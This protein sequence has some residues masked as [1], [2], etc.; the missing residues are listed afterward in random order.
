MTDRQ[1][2]GPSRPVV[3][4][5]DDAGWRC[6]DQ[7]A[8]YLRRVGVRSV[9]VVLRRPPNRLRRLTDRMLYAEVVSLGSPAGTDRLRALVAGGQVIDAHVNE[10]TLVALGPASPLA[11]L[12]GTVALGHP[13]PGLALVDKVQVGDRLRAGGALVPDQVRGERSS[14]AEAVA[15]LGLPLVVKRRIGTGGGEVHVAPTVAAAEQAVTDLGNEPLKLFFERFIDGE[16][17]YYLAVIGPQGVVQELVGVGQRSVEH[18]LG[19]ST[20]VLLIDE[21][22]VM[23]EGRRLV[24]VLGVRGMVALEFIRDGD[25]RV[26]HIDLS[27]RAWGNVLAPLTVGVNLFDAYRYALGLG[28]RPPVKPPE[29][30][31]ASRTL[32]VQPGALKR[33]VAGGSLADVRAAAGPLVRDYGPVLG[34]RYLVVVAVELLSTWRSRL[35]DRVTGQGSARS[36]VEAP[37]T[38]PTTSKPTDR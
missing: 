5:L 7:L 29:A 16:P 11:A 4:F 38:R 33:A 15:R 26:W 34:P 36:M 3:L 14:A 2:N 27:T 23:A 20:G 8:A 21:P 24:E 32:A 1:G 18:P 25:G 22:D 28:A 10:R 12:I 17:V 35:T 30:S 13:E 19:P 9:R 6:F 31:W 37:P